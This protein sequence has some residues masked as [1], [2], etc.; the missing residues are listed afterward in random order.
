[1]R[2]AFAALRG[3]SRPPTTGRSRTLRFWLD[4]APGSVGTTVEGGASPLG[5]L[6]LLPR[7]VPADAPL[8]PAENFPTV[9]RPAGF[10]EIYRNRLVAR[11]RRA[12]LRLHVLH[13]DA[14]PRP[15][16]RNSV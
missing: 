1:M 5:G 13:R 11:V 15:T 2:A 9:S 6:L 12:R 8:L 4:G 3:R 14:R 10:A 16:S 7:R